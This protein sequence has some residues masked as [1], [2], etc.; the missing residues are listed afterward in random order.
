M[1]KEVEYCISIA[2]QWKY[3]NKFQKGLNV[4]SINP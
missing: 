3:C 2:F 1:K 4:L